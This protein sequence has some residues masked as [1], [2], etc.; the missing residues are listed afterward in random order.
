MIERLRDLIGNDDVGRVP[1]A[2]VELRALL[3]VVGAARRHALMADHGYACRL[4]AALEALTD[5]VTDTAPSKESSDEG[6]SGP[7]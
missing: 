6:K 1:V 5:T 4:C 2:R 3:D 7:S